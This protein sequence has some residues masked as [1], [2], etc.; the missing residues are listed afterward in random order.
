MGNQ[1]LVSTMSVRK[2]LSPLALGGGVWQCLEPLY[3]LSDV[4]LILG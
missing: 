3:V 2:S 4:A 1:L